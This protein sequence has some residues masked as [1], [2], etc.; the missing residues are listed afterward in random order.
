MIED[1]PKCVDFFGVSL[2]DK[3]SGANIPLDKIF[4]GSDRTLWS[5]MLF[6]ICD[7]QEQA[8]ESVDFLLRFVRGDASSEEIENWLSLPRNS[9]EHWNADI[10]RIVE[11]QRSLENRIRV[12]RFVAAI[13]KQL[14]L[15]SACGY[16]GADNCS[17]LGQ[18]PQ[19]QEIAMKSPLSLRMRLLKAISVL[20]P[21][22]GK[23]G[24][25]T[26]LDFENLCYSELRKETLLAHSEMS[27]DDGYAIEPV[28]EA[29]C[30]APIRVNWAGGWSDTP[31]YCYDFGGT[32]INAALSLNG[33]LP[34]KAIAKVIPRR[35]VVFDSL[36]TETKRE[37]TD[38]SELM[39]CTNPFDPFAL[40]KAVLVTS[41]V[42]IDNGSPL[43]EQLEVIGGGLYLATKADVPKGSGLG[44]SSILA[45][46]CLEAIGRILGRRFSIRQISDRILCVEQLMTTG[47]GWQDQVGGLVPGIK[48]IRTRPGIS[49]E[50]TYETVALSDEALGELRQRFALIYTGQQ[51]LARNLL[52][53]CVGMVLTRDENA[54]RILND[55]QTLAVLMKF[56][57]E[58]GRVTDFAKLLNRSWELQLELDPGATNICI[59]FILEAIDDLIDGKFIAGAGGGGFIEVILKNEVT[60]EQLSRRLSEVFQESGVAVWE[61]E[62]V[63]LS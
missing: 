17:L 54:M 8:V 42:I 20:L 23:L 44:T 3:L 29:V 59:D 60:R 50:I 36:D 56:E 53:N 9:L 22:N 6:P 4:N 49:Q 19:V 15:K 18:L 30:E 62:F 25:M 24:G 28:K 11:W 38:V 1:N 41:K 40:H 51:R 43:Q 34:I 58:R 61:S 5:A 47:G 32:V 39:N 57:L 21:A 63:G 12:T 55:I 10:P 7:S 35:I 27:H 31:P 52:R 45:G 14:S 26:S 33:Q 16:L 2:A 37:F 46:V 48:L 13:E